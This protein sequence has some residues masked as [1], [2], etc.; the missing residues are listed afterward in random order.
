M[1]DEIEWSTFNSALGAIPYSGRTCAYNVPMD[2]TRIFG[3]ELWWQSPLAGPDLN[4][5]AV[6]ANRPLGLI[7]Q[8]AFMQS[9]EGP[10]VNF[11]GP[12]K[13]TSTLPSDNKLTIN[14]LTEYPADGFVKLV[15]DL[16]KKETFLLKLR[17]PLWS[18]NTA[19]R[20]NGKAIAKK[21]MPGTYLEIN[22]EWKS[23]DTIELTLDFKL[24][25]WYG[26]EEFQGK[27]SVYR[28]PILL[29]CDARFNEID[30]GLLPKLDISSLVFENQRFND[31]LEPWIF[32]VLKDKNG[33]KVTVCDFSSA[34]QTGNQYRSW[35]PYS[36]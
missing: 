20:V 17:I 32:G 31:K 4:C 3:V 16:E 21:A 7:S 10:V 29:T 5:C 18:T 14:E 15:L 30:P 6:N 25:F 2:G 28:G 33:A 22:R 19:T 23:G 35:L 36:E 12:G 26:K 27:V 9:A 13:M 8:W 24:R 11:Y 1:A 34:G